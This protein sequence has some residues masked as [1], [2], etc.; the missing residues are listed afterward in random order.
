MTAFIHLLAILNHVAKGRL[1]CQKE[2]YHIPD[3]KQSNILQTGWCQMA[4][5]SPTQPADYESCLKDKGYN[6]R[7]NEV[8]T[9]IEYFDI[10]TGIYRNLN[11]SDEAFF[12]LFALSNDLRK[13]TMIDTITV[14][15]HN[16]TFHPIKDYLNRLKW[17]GNKTIQRLSLFLKGD[18]HGVS[19][20]YLRKWFIGACIKVFEEG[21]RNPVLV[22]D[23]PQH[24]GKSTF[25]RNLCW[26]PEYFQEGAIR[27]DEK[28]NEIK[29]INKFI[30]EVG[31]LENTT[32]K[33]AV[34]A[35][36]DFLSRVNVS[37][38][39]PYAKH[40]IVRPALTSFI[41][42]INNMAA[43][44]NDDSG[45]SRFR[46]FKINSIDF[47]YNAIDINQCWAE[48]MHYYRNGERNDLDPAYEKHSNSIKDGYQI[49]NPIEDAILQYFEIDPTDNVN[50]CTSFQIRS[51]IL[52]KD[53]G[54][55]TPKDYSAQKMASTLLKLGCD[56][57][58]K[59]FSN[60]TV[61]QVYYGIRA[62]RGIFVPPTP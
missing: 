17:D 14:I 47:G 39:L 11:D 29:L 6:F 38:R 21:T 2:F 26:N 57:K 10:K 32:S 25:V 15:A 16:N 53:Y 4:Y 35:L 41:G 1:L 8:T 56:K 23:G 62:K 9:R 20:L 34:G 60:N 61:L 12:R 28:D 58:Q 33:A 54:Q 51:V 44:L 19:E 46:I 37:I 49:S 48:A 13:D 43:I 59:K 30:W 55:L 7:Y 40:P 3:L 45:S 22:I 24:I 42:T 52:D 18:V 5:Y 27:P 50:F 36:K 31:E